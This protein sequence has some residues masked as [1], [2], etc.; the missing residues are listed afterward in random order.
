MMEIINGGRGSGKTVRLIYISAGTGRPILTP[1]RR[2]ANF[3]KAEAR[4][5]GVEIPP[6]LTF[7]EAKA[8]AKRF[9][10]DQ[11]RQEI[12]RRGG[13]LIDN[14]DELFELL[15]EEKLR[16]KIATIT[17][18]VPVTMEGQYQG[19]MDILHIQSVE[20]EGGGEG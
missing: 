1:T 15:L 8:I 4:K 18:C 2:Q 17:I 9:D 13:Y 19:G 3:V 14:A 12:N 11:T 10:G 16:T 20:A 5:L 6:V 7:S